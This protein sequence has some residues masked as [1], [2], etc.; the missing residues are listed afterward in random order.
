MA[1]IAVL[2]TKHSWQIQVKCE[3]KTGPVWMVL[4]VQQEER[5]PGG[6]ELCWEVLPTL[7]CVVK[8]TV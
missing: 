4:E 3:K 7:S 8:I 1:N 6:G 2:C 5:K